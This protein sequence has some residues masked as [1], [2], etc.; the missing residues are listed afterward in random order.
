[1]PLRILLKSKLA[2]L[3]LVALFA[4]M[5]GSRAEEIASQPSPPSVHHI[6]FEVS[7]LKA[8]IAFYRDLMG[9]HLIS[10]S[11]DFATLE[12]ATSES[13]SGGN[14]GTGKHQEQV[15]NGWR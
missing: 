4:C 11:G 9:L 8:S 14:G 12:A 3:L 6:L 1:M 15:E 5:S 13:T 10:Q 7:D 2:R